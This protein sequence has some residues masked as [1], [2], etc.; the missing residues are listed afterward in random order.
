MPHRQL[1]G[2]GTQSNPYLITSGADLGYLSKNYTKI[3]GAASTSSAPH[4]YIKLTQNIDLSSHYWVPIGSP[5]ESFSDTYAFCG[6]FD[7][8]YHT[9][10]G[11]NCENK[12]LSGLFTSTG[13]H[14]STSSLISEI[15]NLR[16]ID[17]NITGNVQYAGFLSA[18]SYG[19]SISNVQITGHIESTYTTTNSD[20]PSY[21]GGLIGR[22]E[23]TGSAPKTLNHHNISSC[24]VYSTSISGFDIVGGLVGCIYDYDGSYKI[25]SCIVRGVSGT[26]NKRI[27][28][29]SGDM[30]SW[31]TRSSD[32]SS[33]VS[34]C[35]I[36]IWMDADTNVGG[37]VGYVHDSMYSG[38]SCT[39][40]NISING[41][42]PSK[43][44]YKGALFG[45]SNTAIS[46]NR[47]S[48]IFI[49]SDQ[50]SIETSGTNITYSSYIQEIGWYNKDYAHSN[51]AFHNAYQMNLTMG[52]QGSTGIYPID[53]YWF[54]KN[55]SVKRVYRIYLY[56]SENI[57]ESISHSSSTYIYIFVMVRHLNFRKSKMDMEIFIMRSHP[58]YLV[59]Q[60]R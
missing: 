41:F 56:Y 11:L 5:S 49:D 21:G 55:Y 29:I 16:I 6:V 44:S 34:N 27:G 45:N 28:G 7:G 2:G 1:G 54:L 35:S 46:T 39:F 30:R 24:D 18:I 25:D 4:T 40:N 57:F 43:G 8:D 52:I 20:W 32:E 53:N 51:R 17:S 3:M 31:R 23:Q 48:N 37:I 33:S 10:S 14:G 50:C 47:Y 15:K 38:T 26:A 59:S 42:H 13:S 9:I 60:Y 19:I 58:L 36:A 12:L 22:A